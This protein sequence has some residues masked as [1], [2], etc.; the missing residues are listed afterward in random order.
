MRHPATGATF[1]QASSASTSVPNAIDCKRAM[2][3]LDEVLELIRQD[4]DGDCSDVDDHDHITS[5]KSSSASS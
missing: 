1:Y 2:A 4:E 3:I 5:S